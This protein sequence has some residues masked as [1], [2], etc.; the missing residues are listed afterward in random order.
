[1]LL[2]KKIIIFYLLLTS[3]FTIYFNNDESKNDVIRQMSE[4][5]SNDEIYSSNRYTKKDETSTF[6]LNELV[7]KDGFNYVCESDNLCLYVSNETLAIRIENKNNGFIWGSSF[8]T[9]NEQLNKT[10]KSRVESALWITYFKKGTA[11]DESLDE[12][13]TTSALTK[14]QMNNINNGFEANITFGVSKISLKLIVI[15]ENDT[16][17]VDIPFEFIKESDNALLGYIKVYPFFGAVKG[18]EYN[19]QFDGY[20]LIPDGSGALIRYKKKS[21]TPYPIY[22]KFIYGKDKGVYDNIN[23]ENVLEDTSISLPLFGI[24]QGIN[25]NAMYCEGVSGEEY[26]RIISYEAGR[27]T[28]FYWTCLE[29]IYRIQYHQRISKSTNMIATKKDKNEFDL[30]LEYRF[31]DN[32]KANYVG[33]AN[34]YKNKFL[35][36]KTND[37]KLHL[38][39]LTSEVKK[40]LIFNDYI[41]MTSSSYIK[42]IVEDL[43]DSEISDLSLSILGWSKKGYSTSAPNYS[44]FNKESG[45]KKGYL[46]LFKFLENEQINYY[47]NVDYTKG[48]SG[49]SGFS[50]LND[51]ALKITDNAYNG[52]NNGFEYS[53]LNAKA[54][55]DAFN[56]DMKFYN[57]YK[58][59]GLAFEEI[60]SSVYSSWDKNEKVNVLDAI[61]KYQ[62]ILKQEGMKKAV[63]GTNKYLLNYVDEIYDSPLYSSQIGLFS[64][65]IPFVSLVLNNRIK[66]FGPLVN[67]FSDFDDEVLRLIDYNLYPSFLITEK[68]S[69]NLLNTP[70]ANIT[71]SQ[72][73]V[74]KSMIIS[75]T[76]KVYNALKYVNGYEQISREIVFSGVI[77]NTYANNVDIY[78]NYL[79]HSVI[80]NGIEIEANSYKVNNHE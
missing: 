54:S 38:E 33:I 4:M 60:G 74:W 61:L 22:S 73:E 72:Y 24:V 57:K 77:K 55:K 53:Y 49:N 46:D 20:T 8:D 3:A 18:L 45:G 67:D 56:N 64:D 16:L 27:T 66:C 42:Y 70:S 76:D 65:T 1:M 35:D 47:L 63:Y 80:V 26:A 31:L 78:I 37:L 40:G 5:S 19:P 9:T 6:K 7:I 50:T 79:D 14:I 71:S 68:S 62:D 51:L 58:I 34:D 10:W 52:N 13:L 59:K 48:Y 11:R 75:I 21:N 23:Q 28:E 17:K 36:K 29:F 43:R 2:F 12:T 44:S 30:S 39:V 25:Q 41:N 32:E 69:I 15:L